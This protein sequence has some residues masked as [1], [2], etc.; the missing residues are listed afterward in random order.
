MI[1]WKVTRTYD[2]KGKIRV[3]IGCLEMDSVPKSTVEHDR[4]YDI[5]E[6]FFGTY[7]E[8][9]KFMNQDKKS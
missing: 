7:S 1:V 2:D 5:Y 6:D 9:K 4:K 3:S 8:A